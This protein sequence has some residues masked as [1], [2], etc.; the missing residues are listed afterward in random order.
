MSSPNREPSGSAAG[1]VRR[2]SRSALVCLHVHRLRTL[3]MLAELAAAE[4]QLLAVLLVAAGDTAL[5]GHAG[6]ADR[7]AAT[8][9]AAFTTAQRVVDGIHRLGTGVRA[10]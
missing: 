8:I 5:G 10:N 6:L 7:V 4:D 1:R 9:A 3:L 2:R